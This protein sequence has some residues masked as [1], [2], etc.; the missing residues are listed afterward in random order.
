MPSAP[1]DIPALGLGTYR[2]TDP[3]VCAES[4]RTALEVGYR[5]I[6]TAEAYGNEEAVGAGIANADVPRE[7]IF[8]ATK[9]LHPKFTE[10]DDYAR[11]GIV[12]NVHRCIER[13]GVERVDLLYGVHWPGDGYDPEETFAACADVVDEGLADHIGVCNVTP[14]LIDAALDVSS[15]PIRAVQV[16][17]HPLLP[18]AALRQYCTEHDMALV[19][20]APLGNGAMFDVP[21]L[22]EIA[23]EHGVSVAQV[24]LAW[25]REKGVY[26]IPKASSRPH[27]EDNWRSLK[28]DLGAED[29]RRIDDVG[30]QDRQYDPDYAPTWET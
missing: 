21:L 26:P 20:Y 7:E 23:E 15:V 16:E 12:D 13:L 18:Q 28:L 10:D 6:D 4:V 25:A 8:L 30:R 3:D 22:Q 9:V 1:L 19:G 14:T 17:T 2:N 11:A 27:I 29:V 5:H 24:S